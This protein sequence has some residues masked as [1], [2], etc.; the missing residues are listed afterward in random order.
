MKALWTKYIEIEM[1]FHI[2][3]LEELTNAHHCLF[4]AEKVCLISFL[5]SLNSFICSLSLKWI[6]LLD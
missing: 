3:A 5:I 6:K 1:Q 4:D 2:K